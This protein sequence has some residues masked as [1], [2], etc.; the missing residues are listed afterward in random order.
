MLVA[1]VTHLHMLDF[2]EVV[3]GEEGGVWYDQLHSDPFKSEITCTDNIEHEHK[4]SIN[5]QYN[6]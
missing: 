3:L 6:N 4:H 2:L 5:S 1:V